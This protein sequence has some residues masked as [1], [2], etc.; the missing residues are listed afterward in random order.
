MS[1]PLQATILNGNN[2]QV[3]GIYPV[4]DYDLIYDY[5]DNSNSTFVL[6]DNG[7]SSLGDYIAIRIQNSSNLLYFGVLS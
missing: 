1:I 4:L 2:L 3:K 7:A 6:N 5:I